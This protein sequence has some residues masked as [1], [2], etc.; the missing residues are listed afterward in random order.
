[1][2]TFV[3]PVVFLCLSAPLFWLGLQISIE[4]SSP[5]VALGADP[6]EAIVHFLGEWGIR[7][8]LLA[9]AIS[10]LQKALK[11]S[12]IGR[13]RRMVGLFAFTYIALHFLAY[14]FFYIEFDVLA[15]IE[16]L[17]DRAYI[18]AGI[19]S[20]VCLLPMAITSTAGWQRRLRRQWLR[21]HRLIYPAVA[22]A[23][24]HLYWLTRDGFAEVIAYTLGF[25]VLLAYRWR[26]G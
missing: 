6:G 17:V 13:Q 2:T 4:V 5:T 14:L 26:R 15:M 21:L 3:K 7:V 9:F 12:I 22:L 10:P 23:L 25:L 18:T 16:D 19:A 11:Q 24:I 20:F 1:M 8:L